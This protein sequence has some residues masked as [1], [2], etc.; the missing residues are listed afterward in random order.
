LGAARI[1]SGGAFGRGV[2]GE[3]R[4]SVPG[5]DSTGTTLDSVGTALM[6]MVSAACMYFSRSMGETPRTS[7]MVSKP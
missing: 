1:L 3:E 2:F 5:M 7:P 6:M 4:K